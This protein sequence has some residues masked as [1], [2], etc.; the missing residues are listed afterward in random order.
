MARPAT[1][2]A[3]RLRE[4]SKAL[5][6]AKRLPKKTTLTAKPMCELLGVSWPTL[7]KWCDEIPGFAT[8][9][10]FTRGA[11]GIEWTFRPVA[12]VNAIIKHFE[13]ERDKRAA[14]AKRVRQMVGA[15]DLGDAGEDLSIEEL[16]KL[17]RLSAE[18]QG[19]KERA[20]QLIDAGKAAAA[21]TMF[22]STVQQAVLRAA[23]EED[24]T[25]QWPPEI[26][27]SFENATRRILLRI[28]QAGQDCLKLL[29]GNAAQP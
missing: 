27:E 3:E 2:P 18:L 26:R 6:K 25:G 29:R 5:E 12:T 13:G 9:G 7:V 17:V 1:S 10:A 28:E 22:C 11:Q 24:Q 21:I 16:S 15:Q 23:Q 20:G 8:G 14:R 19:S 4:L